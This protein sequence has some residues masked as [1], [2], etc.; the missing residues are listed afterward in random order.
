MSN[1]MKCHQLL[2]YFENT[3]IKDIKPEVWNLFNS[4][5]KTNNKIEG[6]HS[7]LNK[8]INKSHP[9][10]FTLIK[11]LKQQQSTVLIDYE[12]VK[13]A[14]VIREQ[15][16]KIKQKVLQI[17][18][19][20]IQHK[21][22]TDFKDLLMSICEYIQYPHEYW[23]NDNKFS[24]TD[25][26]NSTDDD[27]DTNDAQQNINNNGVNTPTRIFSLCKSRNCPTFRDKF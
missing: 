25:D 15:S 7:G 16:K 12:R 6:F 21:N 17:E 5:I 11:Y 10:T 18:L 9:N 3:W 14:Q 24:D 4:D 22:N 20:K 13:Q 1:D 27:E 26:E 23:F 19:I 2:E 8:L